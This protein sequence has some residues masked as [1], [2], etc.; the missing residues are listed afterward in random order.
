[1]KSFAYILALGLISIAPGAFAQTCGSPGGAATSTPFTTSGNTC[2]GTNEFAFVCGGGLNTYGPTNVYQVEVGSGNNFTVTVTPTASP[3]TYDTAI[4]LV[5]P[6]A[7]TQA[8]ACNGDA[9][10][11]GTGGAESFTSAGL[12]PGTYYL[13]VGSTEA[14]GC[15]AY[16][17][18]ITG[19]LPVELKSFS[20]GS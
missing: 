9:D 18:S 11:N 10:D 14:S 4:Y 15:G 1:M 20:I 7:C 5:G 13:V 19:T 6:N 12:T 17:V 8:A 3:A 2:G 16:D